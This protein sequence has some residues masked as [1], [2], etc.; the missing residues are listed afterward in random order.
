MMIKLHDLLEAAPQ[1]RTKAGQKE[2]RA[3]T[4]KLEILKRIDIPSRHNSKFISA[5]KSAQKSVVNIETII[6]MSGTL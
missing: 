2:L 4:K 5:I 3:I 6:R 1:M